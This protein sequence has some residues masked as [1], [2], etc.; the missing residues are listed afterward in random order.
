MLHVIA[1]RPVA[2][3]LSLAMPIDDTID[4]ARCFE[5]CVDCLAAVL[6][7]DRL[8]AELLLYALVAKV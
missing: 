8:C 4:A 1:R 3:L 7:G 5:L 6:H 2:N